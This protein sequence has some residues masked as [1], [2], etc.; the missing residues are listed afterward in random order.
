LQLPLLQHPPNPPH[1]L[2]LCVLEAGRTWQRVVLAQAKPYF[3]GAARIVDPI[4]NG[5]NT[6]QHVWG[7]F[8]QEL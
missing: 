3:L 6:G 4:M 8:S 1:P 5:I 7:K 2:A